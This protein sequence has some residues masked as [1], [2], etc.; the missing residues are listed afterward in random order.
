M[1]SD[2]DI[3]YFTSYEAG[4]K[5]HYWNTYWIDIGEDRKYQGQ[6]KKGKKGC[7][8]VF[9]GLGTI[10]FKDGSVYRGQTKDGLFH[11]KGHMV[12]SDG[13]IY[14]GEF[15]EGNANG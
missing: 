12:Y 8:D 3:S 6:W 5:N 4:G 1:F 10:K 13:D 15:I 7:R 11:G 9:D 2:K 14:H